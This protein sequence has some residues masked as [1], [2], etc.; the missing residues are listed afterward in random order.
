M[1]EDSIQERIYLAITDLL[2][3]DLQPTA[4]YL[5]GHEYALLRSTETGLRSIRPGFGDVPDTVMGIPL[6]R[7]ADSRHFAVVH[8]LS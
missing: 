3:R 6:F 1:A 4:V 7:V 8:S 5:G 2:R